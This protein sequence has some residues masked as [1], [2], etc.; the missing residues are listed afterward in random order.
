M[1][2]MS[3]VFGQTEVAL[4]VVASKAATMKANMKLHAVA[5]SLN[6]KR[7]RDKY[8]PDADLISSTS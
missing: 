2:S 5:T 8:T 1:S 6:G 3:Q 4:Y 7:G